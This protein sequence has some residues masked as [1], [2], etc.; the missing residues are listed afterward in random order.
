MIRGIG[1]VTTDE[2]NGNSSY[3]AMQLWLNRR[4][5]NRLAFQAAYTW[6]HAI[7]DV[8]LTSFTNTTS[9]PFN[10]AADKGDADLDR[11]QTFVGNL[12]YVLPSFQQWGRAAELILG[13]WQL[14]GIVSY[15]GRYSDRCHHRLQ[16]AWYR[17]CR[18]AASELHR[19]PTL[20]RRRSD[21]APESRGFRQTGARPTGNVRQRLGARKT[22]HQHRFF[23]GQELEIPRT[24][25]IP[26]P[27]GIL[28]RLQS[29]KLR[30]V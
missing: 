18:R 6:G 21:A 23:N 11:R 14:N 27:C 28:Q 2:S 30:W 12:V 1:N 26:V 25:R 9:D 24:L 15:F 17:E 13:D 29:R 3:H 16:Y 19:S 10:F 22:D 5:T 20:S 4:F 8:A 7:S